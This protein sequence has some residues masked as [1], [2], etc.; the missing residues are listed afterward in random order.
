MA[1]KFN[2]KLITIRRKSLYAT[3]Q[4]KNN[5]QAPNAKSGPLQGVFWENL[6]SLG[7]VL[8]GFEDCVEPDIDEYGVGLC[9]PS[10]ELAMPATW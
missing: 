9:G 10:D 6:A 4:Q 1:S 7:H 2:D 5:R 8:G 3:R